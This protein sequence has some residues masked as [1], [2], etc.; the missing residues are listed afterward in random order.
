MNANRYFSELYTKLNERSPGLFPQE[1]I[2]PLADVYEDACIRPFFPDLWLEVPLI[3]IPRAD[4]HLMYGKEDLSP[5][6][7]LPGGGFGYQPLFDWFAAYGDPSAGIAL[8]VDVPENGAP[9]AGTAY[10]TDNADIRYVEAYFAACGNPDAVPLL[11]QTLDLLPDGFSPWYY[12][13]MQ[14][15]PGRYCRVDCMVSRRNTESYLDDPSVFGRH[16]TQIGYAFDLSCLCDFVS[17]LAS[18][19]F[20]LE[21]QLDRLPDGSMRDTFSLS[22]GFGQNRLSELIRSFEEGSGAGLISL[23][24]SRGI[25]DERAEQI[26]ETVF[27]WLF[28]ADH[29][30]PASGPAGFLSRPGFIKTV[31]VNGKP[32]ISKLY[33]VVGKIGSA[34]APDPE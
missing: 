11:H 5:C 31:W 30:D 27:G 24:M 1:R 10:R 8:S 22:V 26:G 3:G 7:T 19:G 29:S 25:A 13:S 28:Q 2:R 16:L 15:R 32:Q 17:D 9:C 6:C 20:P 4:I 14:N 12:A 21:V 33:C 23:L 34:K 18:F